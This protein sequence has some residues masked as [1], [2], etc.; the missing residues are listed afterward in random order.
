M[1]AIADK[2]PAVDPL[3]P[4]AQ[5]VDWVRGHVGGQTSCETVV[6]SAPVSSRPDIVVVSGWYPLAV[7]KP[8]ITGHSSVTF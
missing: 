6:T 4:K 2:A 8:C 3:N 7:T 1:I 5:K